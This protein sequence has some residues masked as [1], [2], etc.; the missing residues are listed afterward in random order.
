MSTRFFE[1]GDN[2]RGKFAE[3]YPRQSLKCRRERPAYNLI[4][5]PLQCMGVLNDFKWSSESFNLSHVSTCGIWNFAR[6]GKEVTW[7]VK[8]ESIRWTNSSKL[9]DTHPLMAFI[10]T[11][12]FSF[13][14]YI[15]WAM[16]IALIS[17][18]DG[19]LV[20]SGPSCLLGMLLSSWSS[21]SYQSLC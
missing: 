4:W 3:P 19:R 1:G 18:L 12:I 7:A 5:D 11:S 17:I 2:V 10:I 9:V 15:S 21:L 6:K 14:I 8:G 13:I 16:H 20:L